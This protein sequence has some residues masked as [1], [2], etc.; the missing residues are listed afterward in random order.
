MRIE[1]VP[2]PDTHNIQRAV[3][4]GVGA[5][6]R[7]N[8]KTGKRENGI[9]F[10]RFHVFTSSRFLVF[11]FSFLPGSSLTAHRS[12]LLLCA[13]AILVVCTLCLSVN[14]NAQ[15]QPTTPLGV[16][17]QKTSE[18]QASYDNVYGLELA[19]P[20]PGTIDIS[21]NN[22]DEIHIKLTKHGRGENQEAVEAYLDGVTLET[23]ISEDFLILAPRL[24]TAAVDDVTLTR[25]DCFMATPPDLSLRLKTTNG[26]IQVHGL[27]GN[28]AL[29]TAIGNVQ[30][31]ETM[32]EYHVTIEKE[33]HI[34]GKILLGSGDNLFQTQ[35]GNINL[36]I[37]DE[38]AAPMEL[39]AVNGE[40]T[41]RL[42]ENYPAEFEAKVDNADEYAV[43][44]NM[45]AEIEQAFVGEPIHGW[46]NEGGP[47]LSN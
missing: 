24:P 2:F 47:H 33:G 45:P 28:M 7:E 3:L 9:A 23:R 40:V 41:L 38:I 22:T 8:G 46:I 30:L 44:I 1:T 19:L 25:L 18:Q 32:G 20:L 34:F 11:T 37:L 12:W 5:G 13:T 21:P 10:S 29:E 31:D 39:A 26:D 16:E 6:E 17:I 4:S 36:V 43:T 15:A 35:S 27:R 14:V 42:P